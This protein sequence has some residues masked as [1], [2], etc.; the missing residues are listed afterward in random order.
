LDSKTKDRVK[1]QIARIT[2]GYRESVGAGYKP[3][4]IG[5]PTFEAQEDHDKYHPDD[6]GMSV[7]DANEF[8]EEIGAGLRANGVPAV[9]I[10]IRFRE[11]AEWLKGAANTSEARA[12]FCGYL[13]ASQH[14]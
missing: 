14:S 2:E 8:A 12:A 7:A 3:E 13:T 5:L 1:L 6:A 11:Y 4:A 10:V 9:S